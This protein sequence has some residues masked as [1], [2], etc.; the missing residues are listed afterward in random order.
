M[1]N[2]LSPLL[3]NLFINDIFEAVKNNGD[4]TLDGT[5]KLNALM[6]ADDLIILATTPEELQTSLDGLSAYCEK[7]KLNVNIN[8]LSLD[9]L[10]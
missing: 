5:N 7:W 10:D 4:I 1:C 6:Y 3:F 2:P 8:G 9:V